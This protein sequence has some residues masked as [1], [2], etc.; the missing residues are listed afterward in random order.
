[1]SRIY[2]IRHCEAEGNVCRRTQ[3][4]SNGLVTEKGLAQCEVLR[5]R[6][7]GV[8]LDGIYSS[9]VYRSLVTA[10][11]LAKDRGLPVRPRI[12]FRE[13]C[14]GFW[15]SIAWGNVA[16][17]YPEE[18][19]IWNT[20]PWK[21]SAP[22]AG[23]FEAVGEMMCHGLLEVAREVG[24]EGSAAVISH[25]VS[26]KCALCR[27]E[28]RPIEEVLSLGH[29]DNTA[30][31]VIE[32]RDGKLSVLKKNDDSHLPP[33]LRRRWNGIA[34][35]DINLYLGPMSDESVR[36]DYEE[37]AERCAKERGEKAAPWQ[38][39]INTHP[40]YIRVAYLKN[41]PVGFYRISPEEAPSPERSIETVYLTEELRGKGYS[42]QLL[43]EMI[44]WL[45]YEDVER[46]YFPEKPDAEEERLSH[47]FPLAADENGRSCLKL[48]TEPLLAPVLV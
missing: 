35:D 45:R 29:G 3:A 48:F 33:A 14:T 41:K 19:K 13:I 23:S 11:Y 17:D 37:L 22:G 47:V 7:A 2:L 26:I 12:S 8:P 1:M 40:N 43:G 5:E 39:L 46:L 25:S 44:Y 4:H 9:D 10:E 27:I 31:S 16:H 6:F 20:Q 18:N 21:K 28:G 32:C 34:G 38:D 42:E 30:V 36:K 15:E 24:P